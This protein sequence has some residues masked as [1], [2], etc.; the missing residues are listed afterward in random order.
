MSAS[1]RAKKT[2]AETSAEI[3]NAK[4]LKANVLD[5][6]LNGTEVSGIDNHVTRIVEDLTGHRL[7]PMAMITKCLQELAKNPKSATKIFLSEYFERPIPPNLPFYKKQNGE[8]VECDESEALPRESRWNVQI[9][10]DTF[11]PRRNSPTKPWFRIEFRIAY[12]EHH[13]EYDSD[14]V[15]SWI[16][17]K[18][19]VI[20]RSWVS[21]YFKRYG[22]L[23]KLMHEPA[24]LAHLRYLVLTQMHRLKHRKTCNRLVTKE[25]GKKQYRLHCGIGSVEGSDACHRCLSTSFVKHFF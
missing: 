20:K 19:D 5:A 7:V 10:L 22:D 14:Y 16:P 9:D 2:S 17:N 4:L 12:I 25:R 23:K 6:I 13:R 24:F 8:L 11:Y 21:H 3:W 18:L 15:E 1:K